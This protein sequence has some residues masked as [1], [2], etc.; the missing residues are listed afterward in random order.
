[1]RVELEFPDGRI[2]VIDDGEP[3]EITPAAHDRREDR[4]DDQAATVAA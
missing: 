4:D 3:D 2:A 1:M